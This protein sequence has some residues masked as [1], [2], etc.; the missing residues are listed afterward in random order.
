MKKFYSL[1][2]VLPFIGFGQTVAFDG[3]DFEDFSAFKGNLNSYGLGDYAVQGNGEGVDGSTSLSIDTNQASNKYVFTATAPENVPNDI[4]A[5]TFMVKGTSPA[6]SLS[7]NV[8]NN[9]GDYYKFNL[10]DL[11]TEDKVLKAEESNQYAGVID[12]QGEWRKV[13]LDLSGISDYV[14]ET[15]ANFFAFKIGKASDY[16]IDVDNFYMVSNSLG[17][18]ELGTSK[19]QLKVAVNND[20]LLVQG[21]DVKSVEIYNA[22]GQKVSNSTYV[23]NLANGVYIAVIEG[24][25]GNKTSVKFI[26]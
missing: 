8:Y 17:T 23:G 19:N 16:S 11:S 5:I 21:A 13:T 22:A 9:A 7:L 4:T 10:G 12:T 24:K 2:M 15:E 6:K 1:L 26:K 18:I 25:N 3:G 14:T 20:N